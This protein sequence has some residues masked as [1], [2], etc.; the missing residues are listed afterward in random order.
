MSIRQILKKKYSY[1]IYVS[2]L[3]NY[4]STASIIYIDITE[5]QC[6]VDLKGSAYVDIEKESFWSVGNLIGN[7]VSKG[8]R[9][10]IHYFQWTVGSGPSGVSKFQSIKLYLRASIE[11][12]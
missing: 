12:L 10:E 7:L 9:T 3:G 5:Y 2:V 4:R 8:N 1:I 11:R 6:Y